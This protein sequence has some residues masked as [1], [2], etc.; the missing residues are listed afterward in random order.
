MFVKFILS[1]FQSGYSKDQLMFDLMATSRVAF[2]IMPNTEME[3]NV[4][5]TEG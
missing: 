4:K 2:E 1:D 3:K 5:S